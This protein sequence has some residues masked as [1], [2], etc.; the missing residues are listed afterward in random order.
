M[1]LETSCKAVTTF[2][3]NLSPSCPIHD[4]PPIPMWGFRH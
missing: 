3:P 2:N 4:T 1:L